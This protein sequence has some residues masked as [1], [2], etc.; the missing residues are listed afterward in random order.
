MHLYGLA[1]TLVEA[2]KEL[3]AILASDGLD[4]ATKT[5]Y[6]NMSSLGLILHLFKL[7]P[8]VQ[9][10]MLVAGPTQ[11]LPLDQGEVMRQASRF[12]PHKLANFMDQP[13]VLSQ[14]L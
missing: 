2:L 10:D 3:S 6:L 9:L 1:Q 11:C 12:Y 7:D 14:K 8:L 13:L 4:I 5:V